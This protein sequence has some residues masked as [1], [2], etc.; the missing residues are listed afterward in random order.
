MLAKDFIRINPVKVVIL[1]SVS[2]LEFNLFLTRKVFA[3][4]VV[5]V[6]VGRVTWTKFK[7]GEKK[8]TTSG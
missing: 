5:G 7:K 8:Y 1:S 2:C 6:E 4:G 3:V